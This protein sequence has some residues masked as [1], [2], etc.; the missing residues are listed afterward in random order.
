MKTVFS[1]ILISFSLSAFA[2]LPEFCRPRVEEVAKDFIQ[3]KEEHCDQELASD[4]L[5]LQEM[6]R[7][8]VENLGK[9]CQMEVLTGSEGFKNEMHLSSDILSVDFSK[10]ALA[11][12]DSLINKKD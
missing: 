5:F 4:T 2:E 10:E 3:Y 11:Y 8:H 12:F 7:T 1:L 9:Q 6:K